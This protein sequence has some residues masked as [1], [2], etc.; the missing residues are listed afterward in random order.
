MDKPEVKILFAIV[1]DGETGK[2]CLGLRF[3]ENKFSEVPIVTFSEEAES[4]KTIDVNGKRVE[5]IIK[6]TAGAEKYMGITKSAFRKA[7]VVLICYDTTNQGSA[8][9]LP[10]WIEEMEKMT[11]DAKLAIVETKID[12]PRSS[13]LDQA[14]AVAAGKKLAFFQT[15][16]KTAQ[17]VDE[18]F[19]QLASE[20]VKAQ[21]AKKEQE[22][23][24]KA[25]RQAAT[26][27]MNKVTPA[28]PAAAAAAA[29][30]NDAADAADK[31]PEKQGTC[32]SLQ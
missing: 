23:A 15:S 25:A 18:M 17:G 9:H 30:P 7:Q 3:V 20:Y 24:Q 13:N 1:G 14:K 28:K 2:S 21:Q 26:F 10:N 27:E 12:L 8:D 4:R 31:A 29:S 5:I 16:S 32:C 22:E 6:D 19:Q 11:E